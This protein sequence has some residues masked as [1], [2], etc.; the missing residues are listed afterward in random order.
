MQGWPGSGKST[1]AE[2]IANKLGG[3][4]VSTD[5]FFMENGVYKFDASKVVANHEKCK[6]LAFKLLEEGRIVIVDNTNILK[7]H[8]K[9]YVDFAG[10]LNINSYFVRCT[11][12]YENTHGVPYA[13]VERMKVSIENLEELGCKPLY[14]KQI[15]SILSYGKN[16]GLN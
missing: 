8:A 6:I 13:T 11:G 7:V 10:R 5:D 14:R 4:I 2:N 9:P 3:V 15:Q 16:P 12:N 1:V